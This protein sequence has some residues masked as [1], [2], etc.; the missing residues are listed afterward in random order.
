MTLLEDAKSLLFQLNEQL[1]RSAP[2]ILGVFPLETYQRQLLSRNKFAGYRDPGSSVAMLCEDIR[3][4]AGED[5][6]A[7][8]HR[9]LLVHLIAMQTEQSP[10]FPEAVQV[11]FLEE[12]KRMLGELTLHPAA[13]YSWDEDLFCKDL[14]ICCSRMFP[15][16]CLKTEMHAGIPRRML[17]KVTPLELPRFCSLVLRLGGFGPFF[18]IHLDI[19]YRKDLTP[20][21]W[22]KALRL[23]GGALKLAPEIKGITGGSWF[24]DPMA[25]EISPRLAYLRQF[26]EDKG[27]SFFYAGTNQRVVE[28][29]TSASATRK[30][31]YE[32][33]TYQPASYVTIWPRKNV[34]EWIG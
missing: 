28:L 22:E 31:M 8:Y 10:M 27:G 11:Q 19:R 4:Y 17:V 21:G 33:G 16:G 18:E 25:A 34:L 9:S 20:T 6:L 5:G 3:K 2:G 29:A 13:W 24:F 23:V 15:A 14:A 7:Y 32:D 30:R 26:I 1:E 12:F